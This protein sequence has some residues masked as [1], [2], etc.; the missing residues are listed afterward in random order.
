MSEP[1]TPNTPALWRE[2]FPS[3]KRDGNKYDRGHALIY[4]GAVMTGATRLA[5]RAAQ[6]IGA[7][8]VTLAA[9]ES[10]LRIYAKSL[11]SVI[12]HPAD[13]VQAWQALLCDPKKNAILIGPGLGIGALQKELVLAALEPRKPCVL[14]ADGLSNFAGKLDELLPKLHGACVLTP[15]EG[16]FAR[17]FGSVI[18]GERSDS[19]PLEGRGT[20][21]SPA[22]NDKL[23]RTRA[24]AKLAGCTVLLKG[25]DTII[26]APDGHAIINNN[27]PP[28]LA[29]AGAGDV[30]AGLILGLMAQNMPVF[31]AAAAGAWVHGSIATAF[32]GPGMIAEDLISGIPAS[33]KSLSDAFG[34]V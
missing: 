21:W 16:E 3:L 1:A 9:P 11:E 8:V 26:A 6:R 34:V 32:G 5:A 13:T 28:W 30:L 7:G 22:L 20:P 15:H 17:L 2:K 29:T 18:G 14:D 19:L 12:V 23:T 4:G 24:A 31:E 27:A 10:A 33:L 25:A